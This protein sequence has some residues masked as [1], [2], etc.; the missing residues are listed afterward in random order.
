VDGLYRSGTQLPLRV[1]MEHDRTGAQGSGF[2][3]HNLRTTI[4][5]TAGEKVLRTNA[6][7]RHAICRCARFLRYLYSGMARQ[8]TRSSYNLTLYAVSRFLP[9]VV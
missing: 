1:R 3:N 4:T 9:A 8:W 2:L 6:G 7:I 5:E